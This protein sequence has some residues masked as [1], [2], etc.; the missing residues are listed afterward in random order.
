MAN[1]GEVDRELVRTAVMKAKNR[2]IVIEKL[3]LIDITSAQ[4]TELWNFRA[5]LTDRTFNRKPLKM[6][7]SSLNSPRD[8]TNGISTDLSGGR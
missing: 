2:A 7:K 4:A 5:S 6:S 3:A 8:M 1:L